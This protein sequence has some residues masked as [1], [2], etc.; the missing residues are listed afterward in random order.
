MVKPQTSTCAWEA[1]L[2]LHQPQRQRLRLPLLQ[3]L[4]PRQQQPRRNSHCDRNSDGYSNGSS[5]SNSYSYSYGYGNTNGNC[6]TDAC[7]NANCAGLHSGRQTKSGS[8]LERGIFE[9]GRHL[10]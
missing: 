6:D 1:I 7:D 8:L 9:Q 2:A 3:Q 4:L 5:E 10:S